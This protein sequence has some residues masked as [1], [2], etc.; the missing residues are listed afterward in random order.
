[1]VFSLV[2]VFF[3]SNYK[4][5]NGFTTIAPVAN[6]TN[7]SLVDYTDIWKLRMRE[8][9]MHGSHSHSVIRAQTHDFFTC[10]C[11]S[12]ELLWSPLCFKF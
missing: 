12:K 5:L 6:N 2:N 9:S 7:E 11:R 4:G 3:L 10:G 8:V 1:M